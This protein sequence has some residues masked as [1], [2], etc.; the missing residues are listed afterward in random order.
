MENELHLVGRIQD[1]SADF[2]RSAVR[3]LCLDIPQR[4]AEC[5]E[6]FLK[7][8]LLL[9]ALKAALG[10][11]GSCRHRLIPSNDIA[12]RIHLGIATDVSEMETSSRQ[13]FI[14]AH[15]CVW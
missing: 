14:G 5:F 9:F 11:G 10:G 2:T 13:L 7:F 4:F 8:L 3:R 12:P 1:A 15:N 6:L